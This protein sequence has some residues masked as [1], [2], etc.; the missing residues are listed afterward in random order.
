MW[1]DEKKRIEILKDLGQDIQDTREI[2]KI[3]EALKKDIEA[4][5]GFLQGFQGWVEQNKQYF[6]F[7]HP[8]YQESYL[9]TFNGIIKECGELCDSLKAEITSETTFLQRLTQD[10]DGQVRAAH[11]L[12]D[13]NRSQAQHARKCLYN[14]AYKSAATAGKEQHNKTMSELLKQ[15]DSLK[16]YLLE[17]YSELEYQEVLIAFLSKKAGGDFNANKQMLD[18]L[19][20]SPEDF[21]EIMDSLRVGGGKSQY[22]NPELAK[23]YI[24][25]SF[26]HRYLA[27][28]FKALDALLKREK[29]D[30]QGYVN[31]WQT[32]KKDSEKAYEDFVKLNI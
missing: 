25:M 8:T 30:W 1:I 22:P 21:P 3:S 16:G 15:I 26:V 24:S 14:L 17:H 5:K 27:H 32:I 31:I 18:R 12:S 2:T 19:S 10:A 13:L 28:E 9:N 4:C 20:E 29:E 11:R 6:N 23:L 7:F